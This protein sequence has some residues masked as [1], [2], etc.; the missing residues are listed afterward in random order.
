MRL[1]KHVSIA[2][3]IDQAPARAKK[4]GCNALQIFAKNPR[5][6]K[7][8][9]LNPKEVTRF[10]KEMQELEMGP[11]VVHAT[12]LVNLASP[13]REHRDKS[14]ISLEDDY[15]RS[16][17]L[18]ADFLVFHPGSHTGSGLET[19]IERI[20]EAIN[21]ILS[22]VDNNT[23]LL[24]ENVSGAGTSIGSKF[25]QLHDIIKRVKEKNRLGI[26][27]DTCHAFTAGYDLSNRDGINKMLSELDRDL[28][29]DYL[30]VIHINDSKYPL[31][32][33]KDEHAHL[34]EGY[35]A[36]EGFKEIINH[37]DLRELPFILETPPFQDKDRDV[38]IILSLRDG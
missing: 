38:E 26:C 1:G 28:G 8:R 24:L 29:L 22:R 35:I 14:I 17:E 18:G 12:Y 11:L 37:P 36:L 15:I 23:L 33:N 13:K 5:G 21:S 3:G 19:G 7:G 16:G 6:W 2:G 31:D 10:K 25:N 9:K 27:L 34:G 30:K 4:L 20:A 32:S